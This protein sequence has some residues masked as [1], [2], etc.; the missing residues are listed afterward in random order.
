MVV[1]DFSARDVQL[2]QTQFYKGKSYR[3]F[4]PVG[5]YLCLLERGDM[6]AL[7]RLRLTLSVNGKVRQD[8]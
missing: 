4:C 6:P 1:N 3:T 7:K 2:P 5:P 8:D